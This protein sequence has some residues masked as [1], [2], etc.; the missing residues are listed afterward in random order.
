DDSAPTFAVTV[1]VTDN[2]GGEGT[3]SFN[4][5]V[6]NVDPT[7]AID[8]S[9]A[10]L[11]NGVP[12][13]IAQIGVPLSFD[14][15]ATDPGSDDIEMKWDW[16]DG[17]FTTNMFLVNPPNPDPLPSPDVDPR[18]VDDTQS[19]TWTT[20]CMFDISLLATDDDG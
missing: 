4:L 17:A 10:V 9:S 14:G 16:A 20:A 18:D 19:H 15:N 11:I 12:A 8:K 7:A 6:D 2:D 13:F 1:A 5:T 3:A